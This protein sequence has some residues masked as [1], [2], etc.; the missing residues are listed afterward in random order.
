MYTHASKVWDLSIVQGPFSVAPCQTL[1]VRFATFSSLYGSRFAVPGHT[2]TKPRPP[3]LPTELRL[4]GKARRGAGAALSEESP[5][6]SSISSVAPCSASLA[7]SLLR[8]RL[9]RVAAQT[10]AQH[11]LALA[12]HAGAAHA[13]AHLQDHQPR[14]PPRHLVLHF[15]LPL[16]SVQP[17][18]P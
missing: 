15:T 13:A 9:L 12:P 14:R 6:V 1:L 11:L 17:P 3:P 5:A 2:H 16:P 7:C 18:E 4:L 8:R 10:V